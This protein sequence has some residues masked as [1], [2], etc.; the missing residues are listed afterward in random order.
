MAFLTQCT[1]QAR[2]HPRETHLSYNREWVGRYHAR[3]ATRREKSRRRPIS[4][5]NDLNDDSCRIIVLMMPPPAAEPHVKSRIDP[6]RPG[7]H[8]LRATSI[9]KSPN[10]EAFA[11]TRGIHPVRLRLPPRSPRRSRRRNP[12]GGGANPDELPLRGVLGV[13]RHGAG[14]ELLP[15]PV[16]THSRSGPAVTAQASSRRMGS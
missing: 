16:G 4:P 3:V 10:R 5:P 15:H 7:P 9:G 6:D 13:A 1:R 2:T 14:N 11:A 8:P 12:A